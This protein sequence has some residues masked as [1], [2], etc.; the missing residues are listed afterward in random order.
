MDQNIKRK[1]DFKADPAT[2]ASA[3]PSDYNNSGYDRGHLTPADDMKYTEITMSESFYMTN[4]SPQLGI[5]MN[6]GPWRLLEEY[7]RDVAKTENTDIEVYTGPI[8]EKPADSY[9]HIGK[10]NVAVPEYFYKVIVINLGDRIEG[11][12]FI[13]AQ[14]GGTSPEAQAVPI[15]TIV[16]RT[17]LN[18]F[19]SM[20][21]DLKQKLE[22]SYDASFWGS[23]DDFDKAI[24]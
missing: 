17:G 7:V 20:P 18:F 19:P 14:T 12:G 22:A 3:T 13:Y 11:I 8:L 16:Q 5:E 1:N 9:S 6:R 23:F 15:S 10:S 21:E 2:P 4:M 24:K